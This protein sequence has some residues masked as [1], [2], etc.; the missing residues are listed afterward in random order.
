MWKPNRDIVMGMH[1]IQTSWYVRN[2]YD[3]RMTKIY[4]QENPGL[5]TKIVKI[6]LNLQRQFF[7]SFFKHGQKEQMVKPELLLGDNVIT[8]PYA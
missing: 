6:L 5:M 1:D 2:M 8:F 7:S 3:N 4:K